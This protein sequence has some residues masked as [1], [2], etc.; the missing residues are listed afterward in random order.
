M[1][2]R[3]QDFITNDPAINTLSGVCA[4]RTRV[5]VYSLSLETGDMEPAAINH[6]LEHRHS[7]RGMVEP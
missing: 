4:I 7:S 3:A 1:R 6:T 2:E 5:C